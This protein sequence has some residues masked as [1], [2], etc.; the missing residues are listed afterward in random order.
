MRVTSPQ[1]KFADSAALLD[2]TVLETTEA[3]GK[4]LFLGFAG[5]GWVHIHLGLFGKVNFGTAPAA[6]PPT[7]SGCASPTRTLTS[8]CAAPPR[9]P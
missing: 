3:H 6:P 2:G 4:H 8:T 5:M 1:G 9:A 7:P